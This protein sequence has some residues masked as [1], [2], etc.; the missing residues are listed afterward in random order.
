MDRCWRSP[1]IHGIKDYP[2]DYWNREV[3]NIDKG[4]GFIAPNG[5]GD[6]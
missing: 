3:F 4:Y 6:G 2:Y 1:V 5:G